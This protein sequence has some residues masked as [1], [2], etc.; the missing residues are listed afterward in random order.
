MRVASYTIGQLVAHE[1]FEPPF[2]GSKPFVLPIRRESNRNLVPSHRVERYL[3][4]FQAGVLPVH[5]QGMG[6]CVCKWRT[7]RRIERP[8]FRT[9]PGS[10]RIAHRCAV[11]S[12]NLAEDVG[13][14]PTHPFGWLPL[15]K[16]TQCR[17]LST[18]RKIG[19]TRWT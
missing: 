4:G 6:L 16:G 1:G 3:P 8:S 17:V 10:N 9:P 12:I 7:G 15:S 2:N 19:E 11:P 18:L 5:Q 13:F 14:E